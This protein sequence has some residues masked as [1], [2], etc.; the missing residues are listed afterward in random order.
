MPGWE[1]QTGDDAHF[2]KYAAVYQS[3]SEGGTGYAE[4]DMIAAA[5]PA[6][7]LVLATLRAYAATH[8]TEQEKADG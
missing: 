7:A 6:I 5:S 4:E 8:P 1:W 2:G 3:R